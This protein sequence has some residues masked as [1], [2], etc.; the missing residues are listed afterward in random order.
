MIEFRKLS[1]DQKLRIERKLQA[2][3][4]IDIAALGCPPGIMREDS[5][6]LEAELDRRLREAQSHPEQWLT[7]E[8]FKR[9]VTSKLR[10]RPKLGRTLSRRGNRKS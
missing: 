1:L 3:I 5:P 8:Q 4:A 7:L 9:S 2:A 10:T 6:N